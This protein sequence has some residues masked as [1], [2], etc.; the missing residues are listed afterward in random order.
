[1]SLTA[2]AQVAG[3]TAEP[4]ERIRETEVLVGEVDIACKTADPGPICT[5]LFEQTGNATLARLAGQVVPDLLK[6]VLILVLAWVVVR[7]VKRLILLG[8]NRAAT[9]GREALSALRRKTPGLDEVL[10]PE[11]RA[12]LTTRAEQRAQT[13]GTV[14]GSVASL[15]IWITAVVM[16][17]AQFRI[18]VGPLIATAGFLGVALGFGAQ[19]LVRDFLTG[20]FMLLEDQYGVG[21]IIDTGEA[22][23]VVESITLRVTRL[24]DVNGTVW[25]IPNG[26]IHRI[27]NLSQLWSRSLL[28]VGVAYDT[29]IDH[30]SAVISRIAEELAEDPDWA[31]EILEP[32]ELWGVEAFGA[33]EIVIRLVMKVKPARQWAINREFRRRLK[34]AFDAEGIEIPFPQRTVWLRQDAAEEGS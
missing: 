5:W 27:G 17:L 31:G 11:D 24:R 29:D 30:A 3:A 26:E 33:S 10:T 19:S 12:M 9:E 25:H 2:L 1:M 18:N 20:I 16:I 8:V 22:T 34:V 21:D 6:I 15:M 32:P 14:L 28:D 7:V 23:G 4:T 13:I